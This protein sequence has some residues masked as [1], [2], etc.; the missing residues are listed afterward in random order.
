MFSPRKMLQRLDGWWDG[1]EG[2]NPPDPSTSPDAERIHA[3]HAAAALSLRDVKAVHSLDYREAQ[4][5]TSTAQTHPDVLRFANAFRRELE[6]HG[7]PMFP[8]EFHRSHARQST[9]LSQKV[10]KAGP[11]HSPHN[12]GCAVDVVHLN[13]FWDLTRQE[14]ALVGALGKEAARKAKVPIVW[15]GDWS[16]YDPAHW[17]LKRWRAIRS[18]FE[19]FDGKGVL[20][21]DACKWVNIEARAKL[22]DS[23]GKRKSA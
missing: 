11:G 21:D 22:Y 8:F 16:F 10:T 13:R 4:S 5:K 14:W 9:L 12:W 18:A 19:H 1:R 6:R 2:H 15:G 3:D 17:E 23:K 7:V 20:M